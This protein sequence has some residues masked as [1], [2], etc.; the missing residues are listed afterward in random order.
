[1]MTFLF[2]ARRSSH[3]VQRS[4]SGTAKATNT[5]SHDAAVVAA[6]AATVVAAATTVAVVAAAAVAKS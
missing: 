5:D 3:F 6:A 1:M 2:Q 4:H